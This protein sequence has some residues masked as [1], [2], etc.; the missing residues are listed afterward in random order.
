MQE[1]EMGQI[2]PKM[3]KIKKRRKIQRSDWLI[4][5]LRFEVACF[6]NIQKVMVLDFSGDSRKK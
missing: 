5:N 3:I 6:Q 2:S 4:G 1:Q